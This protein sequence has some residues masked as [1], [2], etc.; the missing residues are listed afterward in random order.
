[1]TNPSVIVAGGGPVGL[2]TAYGLARAGID[3]TVLEKDAAVGPAP[4]A[5]AYLYIVHDGF[6]QLGLLSEL[7]AEGV[8]GDGIN[9]I[10][11][12][13]G[14]QIHL[15]LDAIADDVRHP[16]TL[17]LGQDQ[18]SRILLRH[19]HEFPNFEIRHDTEVTAV[20]PDEAHVE[21]H[22][23][24]VD[25][26]EV[27][28]SSWLVG[29]D[30]ANSAVRQSLGIGFSGFT[31]SDRFVS[32]NIYYDFDSLGLKIANWR[33][34]PVYGAVIAKINHQNLWRFTFRESGE[35]PEEGL[36][37][38]VHEHFAIALPSNE[39]D[40][41]LYQQ[42]RMHQ[43]AADTF[44]IGR[45]LLAGDAAHITNPIGGLGLTGGFLDSFALSEALAAVIEGTAADSVLDAYAE[46][47]RQVFLKLVSPAATQNKGMLFDSHTP[48]QKQALLAGLRHIKSDREA[49]RADLLA[50]RGMITPSLLGT[51]VRQ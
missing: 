10:D 34:D 50:M 14:E 38:R 20:I 28:R 48:D 4:R 8:E 23:R 15:S 47:R 2:T 39:Y 12:E 30:G 45:V 49:R 18:V 33:I 41:V 16:Y 36:E 46:Q 27:L 3:V 35:L 37:S 17:Q 9:V 22:T 19:L 5:M 26:D 43:R 29:A 40:L 11:W 13:T 1:M 25:G 31:W 44:R 24:G 32:T 21:V 42:Y 6:E 7:V 51:E